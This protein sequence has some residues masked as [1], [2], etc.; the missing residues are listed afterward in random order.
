MIACVCRRHSFHPTRIPLL[1][2]IQE[3]P[4]PQVTPLWL[5][6]LHSIRHL[7]SGDATT[8]PQTSPSWRLDRPPPSEDHPHHRHT[9]ACLLPHCHCSHPIHYA[10]GRPAIQF[11]PHLRL[12]IRQGGHHGGLD[13]GDGLAVGFAFCVC[14]LPYRLGLLI[15]IITLSRLT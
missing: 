1:S 5:P 13:V 14:V 10:G 15:P 9:S 7:P 6:H 2:S 3:Q 4:V 11:G 8:P 12:E